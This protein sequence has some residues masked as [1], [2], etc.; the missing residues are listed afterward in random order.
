MSAPTNHWKLGLFVVV[1]LVVA[2]AS[3][4]ALGA[5]SL[6]KKT[7]SYESFFDE[8]VQG[9]DV[10]SPVKFRGV[11]VGSVS[12]IDIA[13]D[14][15]H[16][17]VTCQL[18]VTELNDLGL[19]TVGAQKARIA[20]PPDLRVQLG[21]SGLTGVKF[22]S[23]DF[24]SIEDN[25]ILPLP[26]AVPENYIPSARSTMKNLEDSVVHAV[27]RFPELADQIVQLLGKIS[28]L[29]EDVTDEHI[30]LKAS[31]TLGKV[32]DLLAGVQAVLQRADVE[33]LSHDA[34]MT[35]TNLN[36]ALT[37]LNGLVERLQSDKG[38]IASIERASS[39]VGDVAHGATGLGEHLDETMR[40]V[41]EAAAAVQRLGDALDRDSDMLLK[42]RTRA[43]R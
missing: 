2:I 16:V 10:G 23:I 37:R 35:M 11:T 32:N 29:L 36:G 38:M 17:A 30:P 19:S 33:K 26:F 15:R 34:Q 39:A 28:H 8:S 1:G 24:F 9:L 12:V 21:S 3:V 31:A 14:H 41:Q 6:Q 7:I 40:E 5:R 43:P 4:V 13:P 22:I 25:P 42:G 20:V 27:D 18:E